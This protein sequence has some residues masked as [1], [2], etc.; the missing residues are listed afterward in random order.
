MARVD[1]YRHVGMGDGAE[2]PNRM[3]CRVVWRRDEPNQNFV[4]QTKA[5]AVAQQSGDE[6]T[7]P[8]FLAPSYR[9]PYSFPTW[10]SSSS[11]RP[12]LVV[13]AAPSL[14]ARATSPLNCFC[15]WVLRSLI[16]RLDQTGGKGHVPGGSWYNVRSTARVAVPRSFSE[17][18]CT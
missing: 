13:S 17:P 7:P 6:N 11:D 1:R 12:P 16:P 5:P 8:S 10:K 15:F 2:C 4:I 3:A 9:L 14:G 18:D